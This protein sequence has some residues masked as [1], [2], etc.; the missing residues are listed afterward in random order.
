M[1]A[2][3][4]RYGSLIWTNHALD[5]LAERKLDQQLAWSAWKYP[6]EKVPGKI[7]GTTEFR[8]RVKTSLITMIM[9]KN[10]QGEWIVV[11]CWIDPP[12]P[13]TKDERKQRD[14]QRYQ[15]ATGLLKWYLSFK[16]ALGL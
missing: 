7:P 8:K 4:N 13:G 1:P 3:S 11:S 6:D 10:E 2:P 16:R 12:L 14:W 5:R 9:N 15:K